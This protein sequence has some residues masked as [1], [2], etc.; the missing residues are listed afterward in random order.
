MVGIIDEVAIFRTLLSDEEI[1]D[2]MDNGLSALA[3]VEPS[4]KLATT[5]AGIKAL[6]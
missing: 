1:K 5:C 4:D 3:A 2:I 6:R